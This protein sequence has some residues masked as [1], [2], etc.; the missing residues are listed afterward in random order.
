VG[1]VI[2]VFRSNNLTRHAAFVLHADIFNTD[3]QNDRGVFARSRITAK[4]TFEGDDSQGPHTQNFV[5]K[6]FFKLCIDDACK[7]SHSHLEQYFR[8]ETT[9]GQ[10]TT[11]VCHQKLFRQRARRLQIFRSF[12][13]TIFE[14]RTTPRR[15]TPKISESFLDYVNICVQNFISISQQL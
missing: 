5:T 13:K 3:V 4:I 6:R 14:A 12:P 10:P 1:S 8:W 11:K 15:F 9:P 2:K 7:I